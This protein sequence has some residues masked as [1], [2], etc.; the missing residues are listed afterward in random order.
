MAALSS[1]NPAAPSPAP[2]PI[3]PQGVNFSATNLTNPTGITSTAAFVM[4]GLGLA[5]NGPA[6]LVPASTGRV[7]IIVSGAIGNNTAS[8]GAIAQIRY[9]FGAAPANAAALA[10]N[11]VGGTRIVMQGN[12][13]SAALNAPFLLMGVIT[14][15]TLGTPIWLDLAVQAITGGTVSIVNPCVQAI[16]F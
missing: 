7:L 1:D 5:T 2:L 3:G 15:L 11:P 16:E 14:G 8:D 9:G 10:G 13:N 4:V 12:A 6:A